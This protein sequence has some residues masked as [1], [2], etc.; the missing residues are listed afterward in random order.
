ML[1]CKIRAPSAN[2]RVSRISASLGVDSPE[3]VG[4]AVADWHQRNPKNARG[5]NDYT[6]EQFGLDAD[7]VA[8]QFGDYMRRFNIPRERHGLA[9]P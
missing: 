1:I 6:L 8:D 4:R 2:R 9:R 7:T 5:A 3:D